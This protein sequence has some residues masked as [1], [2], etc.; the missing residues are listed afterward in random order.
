MAQ[1]NKTTISL[2][3]SIGNELSE[4]PQTNLAISQL[5]TQIQ[6]Q[7]LGQPA[8]DVGSGI[9]FVG[10]GGLGAK[11]TLQRLG[12]SALWSV[13]CPYGYTFTSGTRY[14]TPPIRHPYGVD[15]GMGIV[16]FRYLNTGGVWKE[17]S[18]DMKGSRIILPDPASLSGYVAP[19]AIFFTGISP[20]ISF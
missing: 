19:A 17:V 20:T 11:V 1:V 12:G 18:V 9:T 16:Q 4:F 14:W 5:Y 10:M 3:S 13:Y 8:P 6:T 15:G 2:P 7:R